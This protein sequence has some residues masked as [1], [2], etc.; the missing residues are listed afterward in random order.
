[1]ASF[2][3]GILQVLSEYYKALGQNI[4]PKKGN[5]LRD[6]NDSHKRIKTVIRETSFKRKFMAI[7]YLGAHFPRK[8]KKVVL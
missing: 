7:I 5:F 2:L 3:R 8:S 6:K 4:N 1:M